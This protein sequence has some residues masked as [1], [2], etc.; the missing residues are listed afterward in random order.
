MYLKLSYFLVLQLKFQS[1]PSLTSAMGTKLVALMEECV[2]TLLC[3][4][5]QEILTLKP[6][7]IYNANSQ[8]AHQ[9]P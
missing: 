8:I 6:V 2:G 5:L 9:T 4:D 7:S 1:I 3:Q